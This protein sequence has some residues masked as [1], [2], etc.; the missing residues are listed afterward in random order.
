MQPWAEILLGWYEEEKRDLPWRRSRDP[1]AIWISEIM[2]QQTR[3]ET[4]REYYHRWM[5]RFP[6]I[7]SLAEAD[8][9]MVL[10]L[11]EGLGYYSRARNLHKAARLITDEMGGIFPTSYKQILALPGVGPYTAGAVASIAFGLPVPAVDGNVLRVMSRIF[12]L[13]EI[14]QTSVQTAI[15]QLVADHFPPGREGD[16]TQALM[17]LGAL[18]CVP[19]RPLCDCCPL[20]GQ[21]QAYE[22]NT[23]SLWPVIR[24]KKPG[25]EI[26]R[27][28]V[29]IKRGDEILMHQRPATGLLAGLWEFPGV[30][31]SLK[32]ELAPK[33]TDEYGL[34]LKV[35]KHLVDAIHVFT[36]LQWD[37]KVYEA[38]L[39]GDDELGGKP[40]F[41][42]IRLKELEQLAIPTAF[43]R[44][45]QVLFTN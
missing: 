43:R 21:C 42:W 4:V 13:P 17:E 33:F 41:R 22:Q 40:D 38:T 44:I 1:Y 18:V 11:W 16:Y 7:R 39:A 37:M 14:D 31:G 8:L 29:V 35:G 30:E 2:L 27:L 19:R 9:D 5:T 28:V 23:Q 26:K 6:D 15:K 32:K 25:K 36:H 45:R 24:E 3:V 20:T 12:A 10:K 34:Q